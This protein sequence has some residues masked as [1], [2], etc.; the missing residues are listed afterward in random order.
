MDANPSPPTA[1]DIF[2]YRYQHG[3]NL[4]SIFVL[5]KWLH[6]KMFEKDA[7]GSSELEAVKQSLKK[8][9]LLAT[10]QKWEH[11]WQFALTEA[12]LIWL[13]DTAKCNSIRLP[14]GHFTLGPHF[15]KGTPFEG[16]T[17]QVYINAWSAV[18]DIIKNCHGHGIGVLI[19]LHA[20]P[21]GANIN[22]HSG[23]NTGKAELWT[24]EH[25]LKVAKDCIRFVVQEILTDRLSNVIGVE[26]CNEPSRAASS[27]VFKWYDD[28]LTMVKTID[29]SLPIYIG[30]CWDLPTA[31]KYALAKNNL[32]K[33]SNPIIVDT[34]KYYTFAAH[35]HAQAPQQIIERVKTSLGDITK[36]QGSI[37]S[38]KT[39]LAVYI[40][41]YSCTMDG[42]TWSKVDAEHRPALTQQF[43]RAQTNKWQDVTSG[44][45]F[46]TLKMNWM[47]G[48]D[49]GFK[50]QVK[51]GA[52][53]PPRGL[54]FSFD[55]IKTKCREANAC[56]EQL[57]TTALTQHA[58]YWDKKSSSTKYEHRR[59]E[60]GYDLGF[61]DAIAFLCS[62][63]EGKLPNTCQVAGGDRIGAL[64]LWIG[65]R[66]IE[67][68]QLGSSFGWEWEHGYR[69]GVTDFEKLVYT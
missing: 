44:S 23:T 6:P 10:R 39:T 32:E 5:E 15:C 58:N 46:W 30:D 22:A 59:Y 43:G 63:I 24:S 62:R 9:G 45:A 3:A 50:K 12:D 35:D 13:T 34:H 27:A 28:V 66:M 26:L 20:L 21:G 36:N 61:S 69:K 55:K 8:N 57:R 19:D 54:T 38:R 68:E 47:D 4:G 17:S 48:G 11:H 29:P 52:V 25:Y 7:Q 2:R 40:G 49:W 18:K 53:V 51:T 16:E 65:K 42:K 31:I 60:R 37:A 33:A 56:K 41:E 64:E 67:A 14:I 1:S